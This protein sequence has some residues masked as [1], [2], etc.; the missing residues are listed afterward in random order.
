MAA[1]NAARGAV[2][3]RAASAPVLVEMTAPPQ[4]YVWQSKAGKHGSQGAMDR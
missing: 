3:A 1:A 4:E 2:A